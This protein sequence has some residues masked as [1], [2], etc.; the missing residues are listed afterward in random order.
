MS[1]FVETAEHLSENAGLSIIE[2]IASR[3]TDAIVFSAAQPGQPGHGHRTLR[4]P[5][6]WL[7]HFERRGWH[8][9]VPC[10]ISIRVLS[11]LHWFRRNLFLLKRDGQHDQV[12]YENLLRLTKHRDKKGQCKWPSHR[13]GETIIGFP[14]QRWSFS[15]A[16]DRE[17]PPLLCARAGDE[18]GL[19]AERANLIIPLH[20]L[21]DKVQLL[22]KQL[23]D[24]HLKIERAIER[25]RSAQ[26]SVVALQRSTSWKITKP[27][28]WI[29]RTLKRKR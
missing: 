16:G 13:K 26:E 27:V 17:I 6:F 7:Q 22:E 10:S 24:A 14:G 11:T 21:Q 19:D 15:M 12:G 1:I 18:A 25:E 2:E 20:D 3:T 5:E 8:V 23:E 29:R 28:R 4:D 9:D